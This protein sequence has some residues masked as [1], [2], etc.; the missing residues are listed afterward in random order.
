MSY[1]IE[2]SIEARAD[3][4]RVIGFL[5]ERDEGAARRAIKAI[6]D[7]ATILEQFPFSCR[8]A[9]GDDPFLRE[10]VISFGNA[11]Y[12]MLFKIMEDNLVIVLAIR[13]QLEED[14]E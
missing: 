13:H 9:D 2:Y 7:A 1:A 10:L 5:A 3:I 4:Q 14:Y 12:V 6:R 8:K 11:G